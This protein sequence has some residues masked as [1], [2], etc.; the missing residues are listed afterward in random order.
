MCN[1]ALAVM[2]VAA[3]AA[4]GSAVYAGQTQKATA[5][6]NAAVAKQAADEERRLAVAA[7][8]QQR[9][10]GERALAAERARDAASGFAGD[11][12]SP[13]LAAEA[14]AREAEL[15]ALTVRFGRA[16]R[17]GQLESQA[18]IDEWGGQRAATNSYISAGASLL[19]A[20]A[21]AYTYSQTAKTKGGGTA[22]I[23]K[24]R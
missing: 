17:V 2:A 13:L 23:G 6:Y 3:V 22:A 16:Q 4:A 18:T 9:I 5:K 10:V 8:M 15:D 14:A 24:A 11:V 12:G 20:G 1:P 19:Q 21:S 7:E